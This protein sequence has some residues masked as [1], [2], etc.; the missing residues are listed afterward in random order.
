MVI[1][2]L[3]VW[4]S[5]IA[6]AIFSADTITN[7]DGFRTFLVSLDVLVNR[8][9]WYLAE[10]SNYYNNITMDIYKNQMTSELLNFQSLLQYFNSGK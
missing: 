8:T 6:A 2:I 5:S 9:N 1:C 3:I 7:L 4:G 10:Q